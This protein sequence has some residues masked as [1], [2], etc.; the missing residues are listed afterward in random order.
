MYALYKSP[1]LRAM[2]LLPLWLVGASA[3]ARPDAGCTGGTFDVDETLPNGGRWQMCY[4]S[5][6]NEGI[7][8][9]DVFYTPPGASSRKVLGEG[10]LAQ[11]Q[12]VYDDDSVRHHYVSDEGLGGENLQTL[13]R[14]D[15][16]SG[17]L[18]SEGSRSVL[19]RQIEARGYLYKYY[20]QQRQGYALS[21]ISISNVRDSA[22]IVRWRF[23]DDGTIEPSI[24]MSGQLEQFGA[25]DRYGWPV[26]A[27]GTLGVSFSNNYYWRLD[28]DIGSNN[29][30]DVV[31][32]IE[33]VPAND[34]ERKVLS[35]TPLNTESAR[36]VNADRKRSWRIRD[37]RITND[38][39]Q[40]VSYHL[41]PLNIGHRY[42]DAVAEPWT[43]NDFFATRYRACERFVSHNPRSESGT[44][45]ENLAQ[46]VDGES[47]DVEDLVLWYRI[48]YHHLP[49]DEDESYIPVR[50]V[51]FQLVPRDWTRD[52]PFALQQR[53][54][55]VDLRAAARALRDRS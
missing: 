28:F 45:A 54:A 33:A 16:P 47:I 7:V 24:G 34:R 29:A 13:S 50:W 1:W 8:L 22:Y 37:A 26:D 55:R 39:G 35:V 31:E 43:R 11:V 14:G 48:S 32:E 25:D 6:V 12:V 17:N 46:F 51:G 4:E 38:A 2:F 20:S 53:R 42:V 23:F 52:N 40:A 44:C 36:S 9:S 10:S 15:C 49:R 30:D 21:L 5:R 3:H 41:E 19:C 18:L 27:D